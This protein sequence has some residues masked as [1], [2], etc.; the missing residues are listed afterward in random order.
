M[1]KINRYLY[2]N[3]NRE[4]DRKN[5][6]LY[7]VS[8]LQEKFEA[9]AGNEKQNLQ[10]KLEQLI[11]NKKEHPYNK[12]LEEYKN[13]EKEFLLEVDKKTSNYKEK[14]DTTLPYKIQKLE[15]R[16]FKAKELIKFYKNYIKLTYDAELIYEQSKIEIAQIPPV[17]EFA[18][19]ASSELIKAKNK[20]ANIN[21]KENENFEAEFK[22]FKEEES[23]KLQSRIK[24][25]RSKCKEGLIS[26]QAKDNTIKELKRRYKESILIKSF[27]SEKIYNQEIIKNKKYELSKAI[28]QKINTVNINVAD[29]RRVYPIESEK[30]LPWVSW[31]TFLIPGLAQLINKQYMKS[32]IMFIATI[33]IYISC[34]ICFRLWK[35]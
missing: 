21:Q 30:T 12:K 10:N 4:Y 13:K 15:L 1:K 22:I 26:S 27:Q 9:A 7:E 16:L 14:I 35:L 33:Y 18:K 23:K 2:D 3:I 31:I 28:K 29:L 34:S 25:V 5:L 32:I 20:L 19:S 11:K 17:I 6:Y 24:E 8:V